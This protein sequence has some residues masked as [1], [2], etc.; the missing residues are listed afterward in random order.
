MK[1]WNRALKGALLTS[2][3]AF[4]AAAQAQPAGTLTI[5][6]PQ[7]PGSWDPIDTFLVNWSAVA[8]NVFD[9]LVAR[10]PELEIVPALATEWEISEDGLTYRFTLREGVTFHNGEPFDAEAV[11]FTFDRLLGEDG[12]AGPQQSNYNA[13]E[14]VEIVD[15]L[16]VEMKLSRPD[17]VL[18]T[19]LSG[20]GAMI[21]PPAYIAEHG[22]E[23]FNTNPVGTGPFRMTAYA[24]RDS[25]NLEPY[26]E[27]WGEAPKL[28]SVVFRFITEPSTALAE[29]QSGRVDMV[30]PPSVPIGSIPTIESAS[31]LELVSVP[32]PTVYSLRFNTR[33]GIT[34]DP[35]VRRALVMAVDRATIIEAILAGQ[36]RP[37]ASFQS[38]QTFGND[39][40]LE[41]IPFDP[42]GAKA[43]L[44]EAGVEPGASV[45]IDIRGNDSTFN[46]VAQVVAS[47]LAA[48]GVTANIQPYE[49]NVLLNDII[50]AGRT[51][52][53]WQQ[54][55]GAW[56]FDYDN[57]AYLMYHTG[58]RWNPYGEDAELD[59][60]LE[61]QRGMTDPAERE[62][63]LHEIAAYVAE[64]AIEMPLYN[65]NQIYAINTRVKNF[66]APPDSRL[67]LTDVTVE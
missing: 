21:V 20:Y 5:S 28:E 23:H 13:I 59:A 35:R 26:E 55:W 50:P 29:L 14:S 37:I 48:V 63:V 41:A 10:T 8:N 64:Q 58:E 60:L 36:A 49:T 3:L 16:T 67:R 22:D 61:S 33:D 12:A 34:A 53:M 2:A 66:V 45:Q 7:D 38:E 15:P 24:A 25:V 19:K 56:T 1:S 62:R 31:N 40:S 65:L 32:G 44:E 18:L 27:F 52:A 42:E 39:P 9:G 54:T 51:G 47:Y 43:L 46:E 4:A 11:K 57:T 6:S 30:I 17:P